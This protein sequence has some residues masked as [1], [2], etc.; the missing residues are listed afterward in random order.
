MKG[1]AAPGLLDSYET[2]R[3]PVIAEMLRISTGIFNKLTDLNALQRAQAVMKAESEADSKNPDRNAPWF[4]GRKLFQLDLHYRWS[5]VVFDERFSGEGKQEASDVY[6]VA[7]R[8]ARAGDRAPDAPAVIRSDGSK[9][10]LFDTFGSA[11]H[12]VLVFTTSTSAQDA[13]ALLQPLKAHDAASLFQTFVV[14]PKDDSGTA[15][16]STSVLVD[17]EGHASTGY[18]V[19]THTPTVVIIRPDT[20]IGAYVLSQDG[21]KKYVD[22][23]FT[24]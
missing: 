15:D 12:T 22:G 24:F 18:G 10:R 3:I 5:S 20:M 11:K 21:G 4:R 14:L 6:G 2:E 23:V 9:T 13:L 8:A 17:S 19:P 16:I 1:R 7:G